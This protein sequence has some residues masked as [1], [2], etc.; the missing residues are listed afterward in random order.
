M[1]S[2]SD[3]GMKRGGPLPAFSAEGVHGSCLTAMGVT[4]SSFFVPYVTLLAGLT[5]AGH[6]STARLDA[7]IWMELGAVCIVCG[8]GLKDWQTYIKLKLDGEDGEE[9]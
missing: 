4:Q 1:N 2:L 6:S 3:G 5:G 8:A 9:D 7:K